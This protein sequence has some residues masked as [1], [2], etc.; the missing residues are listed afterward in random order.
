M[1]LYVFFILFIILLF[2]V[3]NLTAKYSVTGNV[4]ITTFW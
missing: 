3:N 4:F 1:K 2:H